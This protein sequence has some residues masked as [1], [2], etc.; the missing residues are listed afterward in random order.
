MKVGFVARWNPLDKKSWSGTSYYTYKQIEKYY[1]TEI[2]Q[3][4]WSW[5]LR[6][7]LTTQKSLNRKIFKKQTSVEYL[8]SYA[9]YFS[10]KLDRALTKRPVD[11]LFVS[12]SPQ[13]IAYAK[14]TIPVIYMT[15]ATFKQIQGYYP[16]FSN[17]MNYNIKAGIE[18]DM[19][20]FC[21]ASHC[22]LASEWNKQAAIKDYKID[23][24]KISVTP[25]GA[26]MD[27]IP[28][29][30]ILNNNYELSKCNLLFLGVEW[31][32]KGGDIVLEAY[33]MLKQKNKELR[34]YI[35]GCVPPVDVSYDKSITV[36]PFL[37]KNKKEDLDQLHKIFMQ[38]DLLFLPTRAECAGVVFSEA[39][40]HGV[41]SITTDTGGVTTYVKNNING[42]ALPFTAKAADYAE[43]IESLIS[44]NKKMQELKKSSRKYYEEKLN[45]D[46]WGE[47]F[48][49]IAQKLLMK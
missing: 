5:L 14:T 29:V 47:D 12:A 7:W 23:E 2:F 48:Y 41:P 15:D 16:Y 22:M 21:K 42:F 30:D 19:Q 20:A 10:K 13:L 17:L 25:L 1:E 35:I 9:L 24:N 32:R 37:D 39:S 4:K 45:W 11:L 33:Q 46:S 27:F 44:D 3:F 40:A 6:E 36:I 43:K 8:K 34:L 28:T 26:N 31:D 18:L 38:T 49:L